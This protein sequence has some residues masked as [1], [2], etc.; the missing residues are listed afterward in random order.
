MVNLHDVDV[1]E[2]KDIFSKKKVF[3]TYHYEKLLEPYIYKF[4]ILTHAEFAQSE[5][6]YD[7]I[8]LIRHDIDHDYE[9]ALRIGEWEQKKGIRSTFCILHSAWYYG[10][11]REGRYIHTNE[12]IT[13]CKELRDM[14]HE[15]NFHNNLITMSL[16]TGIDPIK[17]LKSELNFFKKINIDIKGTSTHG[18]KLCRL[19]NYRNFEIFSEAVNEQLGKREIQ[20]LYGSVKLGSVSM[21]ELGLVYEGYDFDKDIYITDSGGRIRSFRNIEG[22]THLEINATHQGNLVGILTHPIWWDFDR[23]F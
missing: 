17:V 15:I 16:Q 6:Y 10:M 18:D 4:R 2:I 12:L 7:N 14:G 19:L 1:K 8:L 9:T 22:R 20:G 21:K 3:T 23:S 13:L 11:Y 5:R